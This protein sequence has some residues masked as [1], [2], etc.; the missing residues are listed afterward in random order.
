M[1][2]FALSW[3]RPKWAAERLGKPYGRGISPY[4]TTA[5]D[6]VEKVAAHINSMNPEMECQVEIFA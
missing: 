3:N 6:D 5:Y 2:S 4:R 1:P